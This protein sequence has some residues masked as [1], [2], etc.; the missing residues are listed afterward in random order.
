[1]KIFEVNVKNPI[2]HYSIRATIKKI[3]SS[4]NNDYLIVNLGAHNFV[5]LKVMKDFKQAF[6]NIKSKLYQFK[7]IAII[8]SRERLNRSD[9]PDFYEYFNSKTEAIKWLLR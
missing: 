2:T 5:S 4:T 3:I 9:N 8:H 1:M 6:W 7:K